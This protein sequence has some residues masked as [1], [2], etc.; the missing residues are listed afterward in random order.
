MHVPECPPSLVICLGVIY[1]KNMVIQFWDDREPAHPT[2]PVP[3]GIHE[4]D[5]QAIRENIIEAVIGAPEPVR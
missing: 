3:F 5:R 2:D 4:T 1:L